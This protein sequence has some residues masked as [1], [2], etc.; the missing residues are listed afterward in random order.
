MLCP[1]LIYNTAPG[2]CYS[3]QAV[4]LTLNL[5]WHERNQHKPPAGNTVGKR[6]LEN[7]SLESANFLH[8]H[9]IT[10]IELLHPG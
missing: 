2:P 4:L 10:P 6:E 7:T 5:L 1:A 9:T 8:K 3:D